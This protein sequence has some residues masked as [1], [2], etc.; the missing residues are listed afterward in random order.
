MNISSIEPS[1]LEGCVP[2]PEDL[3]RRYRELGYWE[4]I[5]LFEAL[6]RSARNFADK[7]AV[8]DGAQR[9][10]YGALRER[11]E[12]LA[13]GFSRLGLRSRDRVVFQLTNGADLIAAFFGL[14]RVGAIP[15]MALPA[16][17]RTEI[18][19]FTSAGGAIAYLVPAV[20][21]D[22]DYREMAREVAAQCPTLR[23]IVV[24][25]E[26]GPG[27]AGLAEIAES[28]ARQG[29]A[30]H[31]I[32]PASNQVALMLLSGGTTGLPK[33]VPRT[34]D[35]YLHGAKQSARAAGMGPDTVF[36]AVL[37]MAHNYTLGAPGLIGTLA[38]GG[39]VVVA[40]AVA[41][42]AVFPLIESERV[43][44]VSAA[45]PLVTRWL[46]SDLFERYDLSSL[47]VFMSGGAKLAPE[48]R[49]RVEDRFRCTYQ[50]SFGTAEG[51]LNMTR[52][53]DRPEIRFQS[54]GRPVAEGDEIKVV[55]EEGVEV[56]DG[57]SGELVCRGPYTIRGYYNAPEINR[58]AF[59]ADGFYRTGD[60]VRKIDGYLYVEGRK[61]DLINRGGEKISC[62][63]VE[64]H[65][66]AHPSVES[67][68]VVAMPDEVFGEKACAFVILRPGRVL[69]FEE[70][71]Q[72]LRGREIARFKIPERLEVVKEFPISP[73]GKILRRELRS[74][75][76]PASQ[77][78]A[79]G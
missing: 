7:V 55:D 48:L 61:K 31:G 38:F 68:C 65:I 64:N 67:A 43:N 13:A 37:P 78:A 28:G 46:G 35:D 56:P 36:L 40:P 70:L 71:V 12:A 22:F 42:E 47:R 1:A 5:T 15:I 33:L 19:H 14:V 76:A 6:A 10:T 79:N 20:V 34:H 60:I 8:I 17:R 44:I 3:A 26:P 39:T 53:H 21:R 29:R 66:L 74:S 11:A 69:G 62:E 25:G 2:W 75:L 18:V 45:V 59:T 52:L 32:E 49:R 4:G 51:L 24:A 27:Q 30:L 57:R 63:E 72:F 9:I 16:H 41:A 58:V 77:G 23:T 50:E 54:S 73:A